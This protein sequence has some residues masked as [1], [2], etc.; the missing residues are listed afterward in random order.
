MISNV[1]GPTTPWTLGFATV[2]ELF[3]A[4][5]PNNGVGVNVAIFTYC[6]TTKV[7]VHS[8][9]AALSAP[10]DFA[11]RLKASL[12][13]LVRTADASVDTR[14]PADAG[15]HAEPSSTGS[16]SAEPRIDDD[17]VVSP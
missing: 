15:I 6:D 1:T 5:P 2:D 10:Q 17:P 12:A 7:V 4:G 16:V 3:A 9:A 11:H 13:E 8:F 14:A